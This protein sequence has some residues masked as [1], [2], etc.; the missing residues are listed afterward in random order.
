M[1]S[2]RHLQICMSY[3]SLLLVEDSTKLA[4][5][6]FFHQLSV[7]MCLSNIQVYTPQVYAFSLEIRHT[8]EFFIF[9]SFLF[10]LLYLPGHASSKKRTWPF[11][12]FILILS[13]LNI[14]EMT[15]FFTQYVILNCILLQYIFHSFCV[16]CWS[17]IWGSGHIGIILVIYCPINA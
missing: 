10:G 12:T 3:Q 11:A 4:C 17:T 9:F 6:L 2:T 7:L 13:K 16:I 14:K 8:N 15:K 1:L 5:F